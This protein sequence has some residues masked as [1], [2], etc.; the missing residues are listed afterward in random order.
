MAVALNRISVLEHLLAEHT[1]RGR[2]EEEEVG[3]TKKRGGGHWLK[4]CGG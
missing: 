2:E 1:E 3:S 4:G